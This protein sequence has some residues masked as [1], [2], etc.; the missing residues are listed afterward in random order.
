MFRKELTFRIISLIIIGSF[1]FTNVAYPST[2]LRVPL[3]NI[4][5][6]RTQ[7]VA[8]NIFLSK[9]GSKLT[10]DEAT[11][12]LNKRRKENE[13]V[14]ILK[15][16]TEDGNPSV[17]FE[18]RLASDIPEDAITGQTIPSD[19]MYDVYR[20]KDSQR[21]DR[22]PQFKYVLV[23]GPMGMGRRT[24]KE[25]SLST[26]TYPQRLRQGNKRHS[27]VEYERGSLYSYPMRVSGLD[28]LLLSM[29]KE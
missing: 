4:G 13:N 6:E 16:A 5:K 15:H 27:K 21:I 8:F 28:E 11:S 10:Q 17:E 2:N 19:N 22:Y 18:V 26:S 9:A 25:I 12:Y 1:I 14:L 24:S 23:T 3:G 7:N 29:N 20:L